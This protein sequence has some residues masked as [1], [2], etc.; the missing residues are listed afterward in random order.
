MSDQLIHELILLRRTCLVSR[1]RG[2]LLTWSKIGRF[3]EV[4]IHA[5]GRRP[6]MFSWSTVAEQRGVQAILASCSRRWSEGGDYSCHHHHRHFVALLSKTIPSCCKNCHLDAITSTHL[7]VVDPVCHAWIY[8]P[9][10]PIPGVVILQGLG[11]DKPP[12]E[13][14]LLF[15]CGD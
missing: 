14:H 5:T 12:L 11:A 10:T 7:C 2:R 1:K 8:C 15:L 13:G 6:W 4:S 9:F 3:K